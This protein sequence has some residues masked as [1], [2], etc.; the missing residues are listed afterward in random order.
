MGPDTIP[1]PDTTVI[2]REEQL[3]QGEGTVFKG[4]PN[5]GLP[6]EDKQGGSPQFAEAAG[7]VGHYQGATPP[8]E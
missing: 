3:S 2:T 1:P 8:G 7:Q 5:L 4:A 6:P